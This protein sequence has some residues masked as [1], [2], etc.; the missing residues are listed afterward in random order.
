MKSQIGIVIVTHGSLGEALLDTCS[1]ITGE[2]REITSISVQAG[3]DVEETRGRI[4]GAIEAVKGDK[5]VILLVDMFGGTP[6]NISLSFLGPKDIEVV[7]GV[8]LPML[9]KLRSLGADLTLREAALALGDYGRE[10]I[11]VATEYLEGN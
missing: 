1:M 5:G 8:N 3:D 2:A 11:K 7:T 4:A 9:T 6:S 10:Y